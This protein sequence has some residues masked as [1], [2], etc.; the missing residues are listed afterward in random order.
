MNSQVEY[1]LGKEQ[2]TQKS[3][4]WYK[5]R[6]NIITASSAASL[7]TKTE[8]ACKDYVKQFNLQ[9]IFKYDNKCCNPYSNKKS[10][11]KSKAGLDTTPFTGNSATFWGQKYEPIATNVYSLI[12]SKD[13]LEFG[14]IIH[15]D[16]EWLGAS[17]DGITPDGVML[18]IKCPSRRKITGT[19]PFYYW[20]QVQLQL[21][22]CN[23]N[24]CDFLEC[25]FIEYLTFE[26]FLDDTIDDYTI[27]YKGVIIE[28]LDDSLP[29]EEKYVY[30]D[31]NSINNISKIRELINEYSQE[32]CKVVFWKL[33]N[34]S[35]TN[36]LRKENWFKSV[37]PL[38][39]EEFDFIQEVKRDPMLLGE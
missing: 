22:V 2:F 19:P 10:Y 23:L 28:K 5:A 7:L 29:L 27:Y 9:E 3:D 39:K 32:N 6:Q 21:E 12:K 1:L 20:I 34:Y 30:P 37:M 38:L 33:V 11:I 8:D 17:P 4:G 16:L 25:E 13:V 15:D 24:E 18:E 26:E 35:I 31:K 14:L 36:I